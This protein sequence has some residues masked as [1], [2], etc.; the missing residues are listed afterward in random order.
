MS[1]CLC[2]ISFNVNASNCTHTREEALAWVKE[3][4]GTRIGDGQCPALAFEYYKYL[5]YIV[6]T[7][8]RTGN[9]K[10]YENYVGDWQRTYYY[11]GYVPMPGDI[12]VWRATNTTLGSQYGHVAIVQSADANG[13]RYYEQG[14]SVGKVVKLSDYKRYGNVTCFIR[15]NFVTNIN[16]LKRNTYYHKYDGKKTYVSKLVRFYDENGNLLV[17]GTDYTVS[18]D[19]YTS[20]IGKYKVTYTGIGK[21][22]GTYTTYVYIRPKI[23]TLKK[24]NYVDNKGKLLVRW[25]KVENC[26]KH[27]VAISETSSF[28]KYC[29]KTYDK[30]YGGAYISKA[31]SL[32]TIKKGKTYYIK[33]RSYK[34]VGSVKVYSKWGATKKVVC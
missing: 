10:D 7:D 6:R 5:G 32:G 2:A 3:R 16:Q 31:G 22:Q 33:L 20:L 18:N 8:G 17:K 21:Y 9:G 29:I 34:K 14:V 1:S 25:T 19:K 13:M 23:P 15:P 26:T 11:A 27:Q 24:A 28:S 4:E 30:K 12:A